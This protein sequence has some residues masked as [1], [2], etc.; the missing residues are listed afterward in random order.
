M[1]NKEMLFNPEQLISKKILLWDLDGTAFSAANKLHD[2]VTEIGF[3]E[4]Y[5]VEARK[6][7]VVTD[8]MTDKQLIIEVLKL[9]GLTKEQVEARFIEM[10]NVMNENFLRQIKPGDY[11]PLPGVKELATAIR[12]Q[13]TP[14]GILTGNPEIIAWEKL[15]VAGIKDLFDFGAFGDSTDKRVELVTEAK[16]K[17]D[18]KFGINYP[19]TNFVILGDTPKDIACARDAGIPV[20]AVSSGRY[21]FEQ[22][23]QEKPDL[24]VPSLTETAKILKFIS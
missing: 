21:T 23:K 14:N 13:G 8:G 7:D 2:A 18:T 1:E 12:A 9:H 15:R 24:L 17:I 11:I 5:G 20:V 3:R 10:I 4:I 22:L 16:R 19:M 6:N